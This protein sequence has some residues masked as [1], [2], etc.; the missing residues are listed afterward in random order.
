MFWILLLASTLLY[1]PND[2]LRGTGGYLVAIVITGFVC[3][4]Y[5]A[6]P[7][8]RNSIGRAVQSMLRSPHFLFYCL[9]LFGSLVGLTVFYNELESAQ[10][11]RTVGY[12]L[13]ATMSYIL[14]PAVMGPK[15]LRQFWTALMSIGVGSSFLGLLAVFTEKTEF[16]G[17]PIYRDDYMRFLGLYST[18]GPFFG[19]NLYGA[20]VALGIVGAS[21]F[22]ARREH[23]FLALLAVFICSA[24]LL[25]SWSRGVYLA[26]FSA[27]WVWLFIGA[28]RQ[29]RVLFVLMGMGLAVMAVFSV[30]YIPFLYHLFQ[31][32]VGGA[33]REVLWAAALKAIASRPFTGY[34]MGEATLIQTMDKFGGLAGRPPHPMPAHSGFLDIGVQTGGL[35]ASAFFVT[36][37]VSF[38][39]LLRSKLD[40]PNKQAIGA[41]IVVTFIATMFLTYSLGGVS[42]MALTMSILWGLGNFAPVAP[43]RDTSRSVSQSPKRL[44]LPGN[45]V[46]HYMAHQEV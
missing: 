15:R 37:I 19:P 26:V 21:Y 13:V 41:G 34:G 43:W 16:L 36:G 4:V 30:L 1:F 14:L 10:I 22:I 3:W 42:I 35:A 29:R 44:L 32:N 17:L 8:D 12:M 9:C 27:F 5:L 38:Y 45:K 18:P 11:V 39:R 31:V 7:K 20:V 23:T 33:G 24:A 46:R 6:N 2:A 25:F 40:K 28:N